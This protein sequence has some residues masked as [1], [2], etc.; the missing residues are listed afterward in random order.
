MCF[1]NT[2]RPCSLAAP[3]QG[4]ATFTQ[5]PPPC[6]YLNHDL[7]VALPSP[8]RITA[9]VVLSPANLVVAGHDCGAAGGAIADAAQVH[10]PVHVL[11]GTVEGGVDAT[12]LSVLAI[13]AR[14][15][16][17]LDPPQRV[18][19]DLPGVCIVRDHPARVGP[20][21]PERARQNDGAP[22]VGTVDTQVLQRR[23][24][25]RATGVGKH[26]GRSSSSTVRRSKGSVL[27]DG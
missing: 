18:P 3:G 21:L 19:V 16:V 5:A 10:G 24:K 17:D 13:T 20:G 15:A 12:L 8:V 7:R 23:G 25:D 2:P 14:R 26:A 9:G 27:T 6:T 11:T 22:G 1:R 4:L